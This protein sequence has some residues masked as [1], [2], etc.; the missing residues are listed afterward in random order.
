MALKVVALEKHHDVTEFDC[1][2]PKLN[3]WLQTIAMQHQKNGTSRTFVL[4]DDAEPGKV[5]GFCA[6]AIRS[7]T[8]T[9]ELP[10]E[11]RR[12]LPKQV[13]GYTLARLGISVDA[14]GRGHGARLLMEAMEKAYR[15]S[16]SVGGFALFVDAKEGAASFYEHFGFH[17]CPDDSDTLVLPIASMPK[18]P[19]E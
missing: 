4:N 8:S 16:Q 18:F 15:A 2:E 5:L 13:S 7:L 1:G 3:I 19:A 11:M 12:K 10:K 9:D 6:M 14:Q 17:V